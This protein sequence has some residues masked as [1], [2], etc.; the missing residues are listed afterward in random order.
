MK[1]S[2]ILKKIFRIFILLSIIMNL[3]AESQDSINTNFLTILENPL[4]SGL[5]LNSTMTLVPNSRT[6]IYVDYTKISSNNLK[7][8]LIAA[9][10]PRDQNTK[11]STQPVILD[12]ISFNSLQMTG[13]YVLFNYYYVAILNN[14][15]NSS[16]VY[17][18][19]QQNDNYLSIYFLDLDQNKFIQVAN[20][21]VNLTPQIFVSCAILS[22]NYDPSDQI[23][24][25]AKW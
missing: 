5:L 15:Q 2:K 1:I 22:M 16:V 25:T 3:C 17:A 24:L 18:S 23:F 11:N 19:G 6:V 13:L 8:T 14:Q 4:P 10:F 7:L 9:D 12:A 21:A 20:Y